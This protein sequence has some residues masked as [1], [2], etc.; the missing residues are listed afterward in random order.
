[1]RRDG[2]CTGIVGRLAVR[3]VGQLGRVDGLAR[4]EVDNLRRDCM[5]VAH[6]NDQVAA[7]RS[8]RIGEHVPCRHERTNKQRKERESP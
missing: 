1:M 5:A 7:V 8:L 4:V 3:R 6:M 2:E